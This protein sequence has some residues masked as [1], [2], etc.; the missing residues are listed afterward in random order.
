MK[1]TQDIHEALMAAVRAYF[2]AHQDWEMHRTHAAG[3]R[4]R[5][6]LLEMRKLAHERRKQIQAIREE[7]PKLKSPKY[8]EAKLKEQL[9]QKRKADQDNDTN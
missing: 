3:M 1:D 2:N 4:A 7:K 5:Y 6:Q 8:K 9:A